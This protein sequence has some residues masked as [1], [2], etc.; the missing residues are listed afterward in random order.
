MPTSSPPSRP[1]GPASWRS[2]SPVSS[3]AAELPTEIAKLECFEGR[4]WYNV[5]NDP[6]YD[7]RYYACVGVVSRRV[8]HRLPR[9]LGCRMKTRTLLLLALA[10]G[11]AIMAAGAAFLIQL[12]RQDDGEPPVAIGAPAVIG[13]MRIVVESSIEGD[14][15]LDVTVTIG[16]VDDP[17]GTSGFHLIASGQAAQPAPASEA[18][19]MCRHHGRRAAVHRPIRRLRGRGRLARAVLRTRRRARPMGARIA[20][21][22]TPRPCGT[23]R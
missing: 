14:G 7:E 17:D 13:D 11:I 3:T 22:V 20:T 9:S 18:V 6:A 15:V 5:F 12:S 1:P 19:A 2:C 23:R 16:G 4:N 10:C 21:R 8:I